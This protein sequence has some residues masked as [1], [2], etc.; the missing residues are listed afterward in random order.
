M[1]F[2]IIF[3]KGDKG[4]FK[5][6]YYIKNKLTIFQNEIVSKNELLNR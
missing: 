3:K 2:V 5:S 6:Q 1:M 4:I